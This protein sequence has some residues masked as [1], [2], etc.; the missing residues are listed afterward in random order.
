MAP[1]VTDLQ[2]CSVAKSCL[3]NNF[4]CTREVVV[5]CG[6]EVEGGGEEVEGVGGVGG[7]GGGGGGAMEGGREGWWKGG[8]GGGGRGGMGGGG[9]SGGDVSRD[10]GGAGGGRARLRSSEKR[11]SRICSKNIV[12]K[13]LIFG[14]HF[15]LPLE[16]HGTT[17]VVIA[18]SGF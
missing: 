8:E 12:E 13:K 11:L 3:T 7:E 1:G 9:G 16:R 5:L 10:G 14:T 15:L 17:H 6:E 18:R 2:Q 4:L